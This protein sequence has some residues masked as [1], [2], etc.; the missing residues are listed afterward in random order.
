M[1]STAS[2]APRAFLPDPGPRAGRARGAAGPVVAA[3]GLGAAV[4]VATSFGQG[5]MPLVLNPLVNS[6]AAWLVAPFVVGAVAAR[7]SRGAI[8]LGLLTC[9]MQVAGYYVASELRGFAAGGSTIVLFWTACAV[10]GGPLLGW[11]GWA[12]RNGRAG[13]AA[14]GAALLSSVFLAEG[15]WTYGVTLGSPERAALWIAIGLAL[16]TALARRRRDLR[17]YLLV[18]PAGLLGEVILTTLASRPM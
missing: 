5:V 2:Q 17:A 11:G 3:V 15:A 9:V 7:A 14:V 10:L 1:V 12:W 13:E 16:A 18:L 6:A 4:G 8:G